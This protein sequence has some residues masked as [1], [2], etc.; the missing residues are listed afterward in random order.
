MYQDFSGIEFESQY[1]SLL[2]T[3]Y[4]VLFFLHSSL[5]VQHSTLIEKQE[6]RGKKLDYILLS[7]VVCL[8]LSRPLSPLQH[9]ALDVRH[10][11]LEKCRISYLVFLFFLPP[12]NIFRT[13]PLNYTEYSKNLDPTLGLQNISTYFCIV[14]FDRAIFRA[15]SPCCC[16][17]GI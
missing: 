7:L 11:T 3:W 2:R 10:S 9:Y 6:P 14:N 17:S 5:G 1:E 15:V 13:S 12:P 4:L 8:L 16:L